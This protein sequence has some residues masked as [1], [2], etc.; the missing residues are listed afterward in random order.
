MKVAQVLGRGVEG[1]GITR[2][3]IELAAYL[4]KS[5]IDFK[6]YVVDDKKWGRGKFSPK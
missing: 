4:K 6:V 5:G 1:A 2:Y 3:V